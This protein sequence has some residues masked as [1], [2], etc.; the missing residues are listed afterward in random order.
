M[1]FFPLTWKVGFEFV[2]EFWTTSSQNSFQ[3]NGNMASNLLV[4]LAR[5]SFN[6]G[7]NMASD[8][9]VNLAQNNGEITLIQWQD[10][11]EFVQKVAAIMVT[12]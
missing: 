8:L 4:N 10:G 6:F 7:G 3:I 9:L 1:K 2:G 5:N 11:S 12:K